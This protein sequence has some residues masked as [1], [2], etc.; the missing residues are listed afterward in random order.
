MPEQNPMLLLQS[1]FAEIAANT[2]TTSTAFVDLISQAITTSPGSALEISIS[3]SASNGTTGNDQGFQLVIDG[4]A[5]RG[6]SCRNTGG[7]TATSGALV[8]KKTG[9]AAGAHTVALQWKTS[10]NTARVDPAGTTVEHASL[11]IKEVL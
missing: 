3:A 9:L 7:N 2:T 4:A 10:G 8:Y 5:V 1:V 11:L 6:F